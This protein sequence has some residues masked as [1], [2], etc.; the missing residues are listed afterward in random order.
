MPNDTEGQTEE[1]AVNE[2]E[3]ATEGAEADTSEDEGE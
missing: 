3:K 1:G 2:A